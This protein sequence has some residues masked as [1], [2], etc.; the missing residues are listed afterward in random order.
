MKQDKETRNKLLFS[1]REEFMEKGYMNASLRNICKKA[2][3]TTG[4]LYFFFEDKNALFE[5]VTKETIDSIYQIMQIHF[6]REKEMAAKGLIF[7][8]VLEEENNDLE[9]SVQI[10]HHMYLK[11]DDILLALTKSQGSSMEHIVDIFIETVEEHYRMIAKGMQQ[12]YPGKVM[13]DNFI[14]WLAHMH[15]DA[16]VYMITHI[17]NE[18]DAIKFMTQAVTYME[19]GWYGLFQSE[20]KL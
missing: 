15:I 19:T 18:A 3:V 16:F 11:R 8:P 10:I 5:A 1:A 9:D 17:E 12:A 2:G 13:D 6:E 4:A 7:E 20:S 14:H